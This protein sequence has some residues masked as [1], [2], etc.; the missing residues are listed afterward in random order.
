MNR[1]I[2]FSLLIGFVGFAVTLLSSS[3]NNLW[4]TSFTRGLLAFLIW[5]A[6]G[7]V[8][9]WVLGVIGSSSSKD[10][11]HDGDSLEPH[12]ERGT[13]FD[14]TLPADSDGG[15]DLLKSTSEELDRDDNGFTPLT[16][17]KLVSTQDPEQ[18]VK[19]VRHLTEE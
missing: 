14:L 15:I 13:R 7:Y 18:L 10:T 1:Y 19:A 3:V 12:E 17:P 5:F 9:R 6:L 8:G 16:P 2:R 4:M 11:W